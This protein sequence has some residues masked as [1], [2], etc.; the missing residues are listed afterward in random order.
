MMDRDGGDLSVLHLLGITSFMFSTGL[1]LS[2]YGMITLALESYRLAPA[3]ASFA[4]AGFL[5]VAGVSQLVCPLAGYLSDRHR[6]RFGKRVPFIA[7]GTFV[8]SV[9]LGVQWVS[10]SGSLPGMAF[11]DD[12]DSSADENRP[13]AALLYGVA[14]LSSML[15]LNVATGAGHG[16]VPLMGLPTCESCGPSTPTPP[17]VRRPFPSS[18]ERRRGAGARDRPRRGAPLAPGRDEGLAATSRPAP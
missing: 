5:A 13:M 12:D 17:R 10:R 18:R 16:G 7:G 6:S 4:L 11:D 3:S 8:L 15:A 9:G 2:T 14:F 1:L